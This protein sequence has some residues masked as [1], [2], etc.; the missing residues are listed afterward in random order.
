MEGGGGGRVSGRK[1]GGGC[2]S[3]RKGGGWKEVEGGGVKEVE[4]LDNFQWLLVRC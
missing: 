3:G 2:V 4:Q 1:G